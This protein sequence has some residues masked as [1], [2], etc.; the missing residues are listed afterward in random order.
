MKSG[1]EIDMVVSDCL[2]AFALYEKVFGAEK[3][4]ITAYNKGM[5]EAVF[6]LFGTRFHLLD[7]NP[8]YQLYAPKPNQSLPVWCNLVV[9]DIALVFKKAQEHDFKI[10]QPVQ[11]LSEF[12]VMNAI[13]ADPFGYVWMLHQIV[14]E[15]SFEE[16]CRIMEE[17]MH[18]SQTE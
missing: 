14:K 12:G 17:K 18:S 8:E 7:E 15:M 6:M 1:V 9:Q 5:N 10:I 11:N 4:E 3:V 13:V 16:R 2:S